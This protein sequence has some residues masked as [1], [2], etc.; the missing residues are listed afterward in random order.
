MNGY[1]DNNPKTAMG[2]LK[3]PI[4]LCPPA[5]ERGAAEAFANG[6]AKYGAYN[7]REKMISASV[8]FAACKRH[9]DDWWDR[10][11]L[12]DCAPDSHVHHVKHAAAC[13]AMILD[14]MG[15]PQ[16]NDNRPPR[17]NRGEQQCPVVTTQSTSSETKSVPS[18]SRSAKNAT[19]RATSSRK[20]AKST[21]GTG[22]TLITANLWPRAVP[23]KRRT[24]ASGAVMRTGRKGT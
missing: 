15:S 22:S 11:D 17:V 13:L 6:A 16:F 20:P 18:R 2:A 23:T 12:D 1:P 21:K 10:I 5:L 14:V 19:K 9:L 8:Y 24:G 3:T 4:D 7:W